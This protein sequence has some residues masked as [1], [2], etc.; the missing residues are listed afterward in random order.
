MSTSNQLWEVPNQAGIR[1][2][3]FENWYAVLTYARHEKVV[4]GR[5]RD[6]GVTTFLPTVA[7]IHRWSDRKKVVEVPL[8]SCYLFVKLASMNNEDLQKVLQID[9]VIGFAGS[10]RLGTPIPS[11]QIEAV[12]ILVRERLQYRVHPFLKTGQRVRVCSGALEGLEGILVGR[13][14]ESTLVLSVDAMQRSLS[15]QID[16]YDLEA[17]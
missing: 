6:K 1:G 15:V 10:T 17:V 16:G 13:K 3:D 4:T 12:R 11:E 2:N 7:E 9:N 8:F 14:G 5:L